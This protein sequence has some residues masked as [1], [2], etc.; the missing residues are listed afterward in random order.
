MG[1]S[2]REQFDR[3]GYLLVRQVLSP[4]QVRWLRGFFG[5][6][7]DLPP[8]RRLPGDTD[9]GL[10]DIFSRYPE[11]PWRLFKDLFSM[12]SLQGGPLL[13]HAAAG[14]ATLRHVS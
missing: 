11:V 1:I 13:S 4:E 3:E 10:L 14:E 8:E 7:F 9:S 2:E 12:E 6:K 5:P